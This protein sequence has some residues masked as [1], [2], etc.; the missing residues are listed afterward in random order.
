MRPLRFPV[1]SG[2][3]PAV[4][5]LLILSALV[6]VGFALLCS[7]V[8]LQDRTAARAQ[9]AHTA[10]TIAA[11]IAQ[12]LGRA[13]SQY[14]LSLQAVAQGLQLPGLWDLAPDL[15]QMV[16]FDRTAAG[17]PFGFLNVLDAQGE[18][19]ADLHAATPRPG[20]WAGRD[21]FQEHRRNPRDQLYVARPVLTGPNQPALLPLSRRLSRADGTFAGVVVGS[22]RLGSVQDLLSRFDP[23]PNGSLTLLRDD[24]I[25]LG[26]L[27][28]DPNAIGRAAPP[29]AGAFLHRAM[30]EGPDPLDAVAR[31]TAYR[32]VGTWPLTIA[33]GLATAG[34]DAPWQ[35]RAAWFGA[36][37][38]ALCLLQLLLLRFGARAAARQARAEADARD[39]AAARARLLATMSHEL[40]TPLTAVLGYAEL[41]AG[42]ETLRP[43]QTGL[44]A[45]LIASGAHMRDVID[46]VIDITRDRPLD[47]PPHPAPVLLGDLVAQCRLVIEPETTSRGLDLRWEVDPAL[48]RAVSV[49]SRQLCLVLINLLANAAKYTRQGAVTL[50]LSGSAD[51]LR[52]EVADT[53]TGIPAALRARLFRAYD[54]LDAPLPPAGG[55]GLGLA[56]AARLVRGMG[57]TIGHENAPGGGSVFWVEV[58]VTAVAAPAPAPDAPD[59]SETGPPLS[60]LLVEDNPINRDLITRFLRQGGHAVTA[61]GDGRAA[62]QVMAES[63]ADVVVTDLRMPRMDGLALAAAIRA[64]PGA[65]GRAPILLLTADALVRRAPGFAAAEIDLVLTKPFGRADLMAAIRRVAGPRQPIEPVGT[66]SDPW[67]PAGAG[68][69]RAKPSAPGGGVGVEGAERSPAAA[70]PR[71]GPA[72]GPPP[73]LDQA[74]FAD[75]AR[76]VGP[77]G[78]G[79]HVQTLAARIETLIGLLRAGPDPDQDALL[80]HAHDTAG[81]AGLM[82][83]LALSAALRDAVRREVFDNPALIA[84]AERSLGQLRQYVVAEELSPAPP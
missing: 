33:V 14:D 27:P 78:F 58:P 31:L 64:L 65:R 6:T 20:N 2:R 34:V 84:L 12:D 40:R 7:A 62:L 4:R 44:L 21:Y 60:V 56:I 29:R 24:G 26:R 54:R 42:D 15:R 10:E 18:V 49:D 16:L 83:F 81:A 30:N 3:Q 77:A 72:A 17:P 52:C 67:P 39:S 23:G 38:L 50:R 59:P 35:T 73:L 57:G 37:A 1:G 47:M 5:T 80:D 76:T 82:G 13:I 41:L 22:L 19:I 53:G 43:E 68:L 9:A 75:V 36:A 79:E 32:P 11:A 61:V 8:I 71:S 25:V 45:A 63:G 69:V 66:G 46:R 51:R 74:M 48:P 28:P 70:A 55:S